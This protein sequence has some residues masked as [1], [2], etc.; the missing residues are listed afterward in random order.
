MFLVFFNMYRTLQ[1]MDKNYFWK[2]YYPLIYDMAV[3]KSEKDEKC[4]LKI[5]LFVYHVLNNRDVIIA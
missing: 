1:S 4:N 3:I 5:K 2:V